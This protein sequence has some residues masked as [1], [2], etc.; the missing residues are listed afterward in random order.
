MCIDTVNSSSKTTR[1]LAL[2]KP[3]HSLLTIGYEGLELPDF[4]RFLAYHKINVLVDV[5]EL[6]ASRKKGFSKASLSQALEE[7]GIEYMH[8]KALG[9]P[10]AIRKQL[11]TD[12]DYNAFFTAYDE[13]LDKQK[14]T[15]MMLGEVVEEK[16]RVCLMCFESE[17]ER[18]HRSRVADRLS[19]LFRGHLSIEPVNT[20]VR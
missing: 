13:Y 2:G 8:I 5:R 3:R 19:D 9:S 6:A 17:H 20:W 15:I 12:W 18:C 11:K 14:D 4:L 7:R 10:G 1:E 16:D